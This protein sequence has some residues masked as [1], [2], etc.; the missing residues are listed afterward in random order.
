MKKIHIDPQI[1]KQSEQTAEQPVLQ[2]Y[3]Y[4]FISPEGKQV[5]AGER[6]LG[7]TPSK[8]SSP[9]ATGRGKLGSPRTQIRSNIWDK[10]TQEAV[11]KE[12]ARKGSLTPVTGP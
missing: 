1:E 7:I 10:A 9:L 12:K 11:E 6:L 3:K 8:E 5:F 2:R 4:P